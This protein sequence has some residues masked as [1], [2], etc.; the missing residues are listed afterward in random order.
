MLE[1][2]RE[3]LYANFWVI[4]A[5]W[6][7]ACA[8]LLL[9]FLANFDQTRPVDHVLSWQ[10]VVALFSLALFFNFIFYLWGKWIERQ[11]SYAKVNVLAVS[12][13]AVELIFLTGIM[14]AVAEFKTIIPVL[15]FIPI[16]E[17][18]VLFDRIGPAVVSVLSSILINAVLLA[19]FYLFG[20]E[21]SALLKSFLTNTAPITVVYLVVGFFASFLAHLLKNRG[22]AL[23]SQ[24]AEQS[25][26]VAELERLNKELQS[27]ANEL[28]AKDVELTMAN[29]QLHTLE[30]AKSKFIAVTTHQLR[31]PLAAVKW[32][33]DMLLKE[34]LGPLAADQKEFVKKGFDSTQRIITIVNELLNAGSF[35]KPND[36]KMN[37]VSTQFMDLLNSVAFE[38]TNQ[39]ESKNIKLE[40][41]KPSHSLPAVML[42]PDKIRMVLENL[43]DN[44]IK[45]TP[46]GGT[47]TII[48]ND[49]K[50]NSANASIDVIV[51]DTGIGIAAPDQKKVFE[52]FYRAANAVAVE[53]DGT[54]L[55]L[56]IGRDI[57]EK[58]H[59]T[60]WFVSELGKGTKFYITLPINQPN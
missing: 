16:V 40:I 46:K 54:G 23:I 47:V 53:P 17:S 44:A 42:D 26:H 58:H 8:V 18:I 25:S 56:F 60:M 7:Y 21:P 51:S 9:G 41:L 59:G 19:G 55:G 36:D 43:I 30:A 32:T 35:D 28:Y 29:Q 37:F 13:I 11:G 52:K 45:Y 31:T 15:F 49:A 27:K 1:S 24:T 48:V 2:A 57:I 38:F 20:L 22:E 50:I 10:A 33:F 5:R 34:Q 6:Y 14:F 12:Q 3:S 4:R 39:S